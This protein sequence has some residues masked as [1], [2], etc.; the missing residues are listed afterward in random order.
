MIRHSLLVPFPVDLADNGTV[1]NADTYPV[2][3]SLVHICTVLLRFKMLP[4]VLRDKGKDN[5]LLKPWQGLKSTKKLLP[6]I[7]PLYKCIPNP[8]R[9]QEAHVFHFQNCVFGLSKLGF[10]YNFMLRTALRMSPWDECS[11][12]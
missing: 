2:K 9:L 6:K 3:G 1:V 5:G 8:R 4:E 7:L 11:T 10:V 12:A